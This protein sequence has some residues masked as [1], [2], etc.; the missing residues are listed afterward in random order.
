[1]R[2]TV[3][4]IFLII[5]LTAYSQVND[6]SDVLSDPIESMPKFPGGD[7]AFWCFIENNF[8]LE[9][10]NADQIHIRYF[11]KFK[12]DSL[13]KAAAFNFIA[14]RPENISNLHVDSLRRIE[15]ERVLNLMPQWEP[16]VQNGKKSGVWFIIPISTP[17]TDNKCKKNKNSH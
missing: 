5:S 12:I 9:I 7:K 13:G 14:T 6:S 10:L 17:Y 8:N 16:A 3:I 4:F 2:L 15:I 1:M 11:I